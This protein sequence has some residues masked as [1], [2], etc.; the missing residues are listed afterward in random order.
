MSVRIFAAGTVAAGLL[1]F[2][3]WGIA[4]PLLLMASGV[5]YWVFG[6]HEHQQ[7]RIRRAVVGT[8]WFLSAGFALGMAL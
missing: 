2:G 6:G 5:F 1:Q 4:A 3:Q 8:V 7:G